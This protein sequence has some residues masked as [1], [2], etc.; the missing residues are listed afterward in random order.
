MKDRPLKG[1][2][3]SQEVDPLRIDPPREG[4]GRTLERSVYQKDAGGLGPPTE[5]AAAHEVPLL[6][7]LG[8]E[9][10]TV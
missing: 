5:Q 6:L 7:E 4:A 3:S 8:P 10:E 1:L 2:F 9:I